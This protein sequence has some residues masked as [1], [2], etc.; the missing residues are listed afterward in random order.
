MF[1]TIARIPVYTGFHLD[2]FHFSKLQ[3]LSGLESCS[4]T[5]NQP[6]SCDRWKTDLHVSQ[7]GDMPDVGAPFMLEICGVYWYIRQVV[8]KILLK[9]C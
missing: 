6:L 1:D 9:K 3:W 7:S 5:L 4:W 2:K 8:I